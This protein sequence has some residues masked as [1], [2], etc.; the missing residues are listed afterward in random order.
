MKNKELKGIKNWKSIILILI[1]GFLVN[2][3]F[4]TEFGETSC[5]IAFGSSKQV[6]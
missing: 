1:E 5:I 4:G 3:I 6:R 2:V